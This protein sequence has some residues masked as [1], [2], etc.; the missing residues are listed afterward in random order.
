[1]ARRSKGLN[2][3][4]KKRELNIPLLREIAVWILEIAITVAI[5]GVCVYFVGVR[6]T[7]V[8]QSMSDQL[9]DGDQVLIN[10]FIYKVSKPKIGDVIVFLPNGNEKSHYYIKRVVAAGGDTI[11]IRDGVIYVNDAPSENVRFS[12]TISDPGVAAEKIT[13]EQDECFVMGDNPSGSEDSRFANIGN[14]KSDYII[15][16]A[17][18]KL[19]PISDA[20]FID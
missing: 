14:V 4:K 13:L 10:R 12:G 19:F 18:F 1:M 11:Q 17:W 15:G 20:G 6:T 2:F 9:Q 3:R 8:G 5:A 7:V 16:K